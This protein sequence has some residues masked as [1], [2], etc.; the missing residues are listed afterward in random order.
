MG[1]A[2]AL[3]LNLGVNRARIAKLT[4]STHIAPRRLLELGF[5]FRSGL[6]DGLRDWRREA[7]A[8]V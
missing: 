1:V 4:R 3:G 8:F 5:E 7:G 2:E 6:N